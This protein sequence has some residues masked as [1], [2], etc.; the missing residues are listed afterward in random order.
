MTRAF[1]FL[2][3]R[4]TKIARDHQN[5]VESRHRG[6]ELLR[7]YRLQVTPS[8]GFAPS[9]LAAVAAIAAERI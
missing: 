8:I 3:V 6:K 5:N 4:F 1:R 9:S 2:P 7:K